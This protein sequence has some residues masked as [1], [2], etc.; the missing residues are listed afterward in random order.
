MHD[1]TPYGW[2][3][4]GALLAGVA[5]L[6][7][8]PAMVRLKTTRRVAADQKLLATISQEQLWR[9]TAI[10]ERD[11]SAY[12][13]LVF[14]RL[15]P[16]ADFFCELMLDGVAL[17]RF[18]SRD[19]TVAIFPLSNL[20]VAISG[21]AD[22]QGAKNGWTVTSEHHGDFAKMYQNPDWNSPRIVSGNDEYSVR[23]GRARELVQRNGRTVGAYFYMPHFIHGLAIDK[24][25]PDSMKALLCNLIVRHGGV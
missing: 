25:V 24:S 23:L 14:N 20:N 21:I 13:F 19:T 17:G 15:T 3:I 6:P 2:L 10:D 7:L 18:E 22:P 12:T 16:G 1:P 4:V 8:I 9:Y 11:R 5:A